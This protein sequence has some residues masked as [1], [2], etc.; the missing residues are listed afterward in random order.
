MTPSSTT[1]PS[2]RVSAFIV[3]RY[4]QLLG[5]IRRSNWSLPAE[6]AEDVVHD[7]LVIAL[8]HAGTIAALED[9]QLWCWVAQTALRQAKDR[10]RRKSFRSEVGDETGVLMEA[11]GGASD[12]SRVEWQLDLSRDIVAAAAKYG[13]TQPSEVAQALLLIVMGGAKVGEAASKAGARR[14]Y[15]SRAVGAL[16]TSVAA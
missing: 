4:G 14:E 16:R 13:G 15:V 5:T 12:M 1:Q 7:T 8:Q 2:E 11:N 9:G 6:L 3:A 10:R